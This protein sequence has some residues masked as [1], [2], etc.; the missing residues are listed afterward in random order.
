ML[1]L[2]PDLGD[3]TREEVIQ[4]VTK[5]I[6]SLG[7]KMVSSRMWAKE[8]EFRYC[9]KSRGAE[10]KK[11]YKGSY[12]LME[13]TLDTEKLPDLKETLRL[14]ERILRNIILKRERSKITVTAVSGD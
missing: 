7:G 5:K 14:E 4:K 12:W 9:I 11:C 1:I 8:R 6:E 3:E 13:F 10:K 2:M